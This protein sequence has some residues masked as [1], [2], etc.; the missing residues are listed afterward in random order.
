MSAR[1]S[2]DL[3]HCCER[4][5]LWWHSYLR[6]AVQP[7]MAWRRFSQL[8]ALSSCHVFWGGSQPRAWNDCGMY[9]L[10][11]DPQGRAQMSNLYVQHKLQLRI[12]AFA[13]GGNVYTHQWKSALLSTFESFDIYDKFHQ[14]ESCNCIF[15]TCSN[16]YWMTNEHVMKASQCSM[17][18]YAHPRILHFCNQS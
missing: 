9:C 5:R 11:V 16:L 15:R 2:A 8:T 3:V 12:L 17:Y 7:S 10:S 18:A 1:W 14:C 13:I 6:L 4:Y